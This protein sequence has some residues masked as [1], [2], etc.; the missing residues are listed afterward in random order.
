MVDDNSIFKGLIDHLQSSRAQDLLRRIDELRALLVRFSVVLLAFVCGGFYFAK[1]IL[2]FLKEPLAAAIPSQKNVLH[3]TGPMEVMLA[4]MKVS[5][6]VGLVVAAPYGLLLLWRFIGPALPQEHRKF[7]M[8]FF[9]ASV[10]LFLIG[11]V[12][13]YY[14]MLP[15]GFKWLIGFGGDQAAPVITV[16]EYIDM[17]TFML[18]G[19][20]AAFQLPLVII[21][22]ERL[23]LINEQMLRKNRG[24]ILVGVLILAAVIAPSPDPVSMISLAIPMYLMF[25]GALVVIKRLK[26]SQLPVVG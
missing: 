2:L 22:L 21:L 4:Y 24:F 6:M 13:C 14:A 20:G 15:M 11:V 10:G 19:F 8:P 1:D 7:V 17:M 26:K 16:A 5:F 23:G 3:F 9:S 25:E 12:F 18:V